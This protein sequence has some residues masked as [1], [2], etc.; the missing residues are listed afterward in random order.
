MGS[1]TA[2]LLILAGTGCGQRSTSAQGAQIA[3]PLEKRRTALEFELKDANG[4]MFHLSDYKDKVVVLNFRAT[5]CGPCKIEIPW[6]AQFERTYKD[7][8]FA[9]IGVA[10]DE[11][12][13]A[14]FR[15]R[16]LSAAGTSSESLDP[17]SIA[18]VIERALPSIYGCTTRLFRLSPRSSRLQSHYFASC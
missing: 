17:G 9:V 4:Q 14:V 7:R 15:H 18:T 6:F 10:M 13:G 3:R 12:G 16:R 5:W 1:L 2:A 11:E 8:G